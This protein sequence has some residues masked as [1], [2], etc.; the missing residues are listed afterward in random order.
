MTTAK[1]PYD[2]V[3][4]RVNLS[5]RDVQFGL[6]RQLIVPQVAIDKATDRVSESDDASSNEV[7][8]ASLSESDPILDP[9]S[10]LAAVENGAADEDVQARWLYLVLAWLF[11]N[12]A[13]VN[14]P[15]GMVEEVYSDFGYPRE[16]APFVRYMPMVGPDLGNP[17]QNEARLYDRWKSYLDEAGKRFARSP[18]TK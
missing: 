16:I 3:R 7:E 17:E 12:R 8:L 11:E 2:F 1:I 15:L 4:Q 13:S 18:Q 9:V 5:W 6:E 14:D 10:R